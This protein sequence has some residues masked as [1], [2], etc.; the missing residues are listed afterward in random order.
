MS[1]QYERWKCIECDTMLYINVSDFD[2]T[3]LLIC[4]KCNYKHTTLR[5]SYCEHVDFKDDFAHNPSSWD[6]ARCGRRGD[7][8]ADFYQRPFYFLTEADLPKEADRGV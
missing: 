4:P 8:P 6:C 2:A 1:S 7:F 3:R 5:C